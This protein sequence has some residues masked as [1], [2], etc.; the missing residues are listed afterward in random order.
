VVL[1]S[2]STFAVLGASTVT[3]SG[4][5]LLNGNLGLSPG[6]SVT[7]F[8]P[9][10][11]A[12]PYG[13]HIADSVAGTAQTDLTAAYNDAATPNRDGGPVITIAGDLGGQTLGP[14]LYNASSSIGITGTLTLNGGANSIWVFQIGSALTAAVGSQVLLTGGAQAANVFWQIGSS[15][16]I[17][18]GATF[19]GTILAQASVSLGTGAAL[20]GRAFA[21]TGAVTLLSNTIVQPGPPVTGLPLVLN[22]VCPNSAAQIGT[23]YNSIVVAMGGTPPYTYSVTGSLPAGLILTGLTGAI[24]GTPTTLGLVSFTVHVTDSAAGN[25][26]QSCSIT[27]AVTPPATP[28][29][30]ALILVLI[31]LAG[32][33][34]YQLRLRRRSAE[35]R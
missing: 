2:T 13:I 15:A 30:S 17:N 35:P 5:T 1:G 21:R 6:T 28:A 12:L 27:T 4:P 29:P 9:G 34:L 8:P 10:S 33:T 26:S 25:A 22:V 3:N 24:M 16:T 31:G 11:V 7:G 23:A 18:A 32:V 20:N 19:V 14:G